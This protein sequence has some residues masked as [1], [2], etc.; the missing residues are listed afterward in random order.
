VRAGDDLSRTPPPTSPGQ[1]TE[2]RS[3]GP[4]F[5]LFKLHRRCPP[6]PTPQAATTTSAYRKRDAPSP[7]RNIQHPVLGRVAPAYISLLI[8]NQTSPPNRHHLCRPSSVSGFLP[9][10]PFTRQQ[11]TSFVL[12]PTAI[13]SV[14]STERANASNSHSCLPYLSYL[15]ASKILVTSLLQN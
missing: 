3:T 10:S 5:T 12:A 9:F 14:S 4:H 13:P 2:I 15:L 1:H 6:Q 7:I 11:A 8:A